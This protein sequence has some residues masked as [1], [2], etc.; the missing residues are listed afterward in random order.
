MGGLRIT[1]HMK[2]LMIL[3]GMGA[4]CILGYMAEPSLRYNLTGNHSKQTLPTASPT[5]TVTQATIDPNTLS[6]D[7]LPAKVSLKSSI[8]YTDK[9]SGLTLSFA[10]GSSVKL[11]RVEGSNVI[12]R[13]AETTLTLVVPI[14]KTD[15]MDQLAANPPSTSNV[16]ESSSP[17]NTPALGDSAGTAPTPAPTPAPIT[18]PAPAPEP[19]PTPAPTT[20]EPAPAP[21]PDATPA[22][23]PAPEPAPNT[24]PA[25]DPAPNMEPAPSPG[26][27]APTAE[28]APTPTP[29]P[30]PASGAAVDVVKAMQDSIKSGQ[31]KEFTFEQVLAWKDEG[32]ESVGGDTFQVGSCSYK[33]ET[34]FGVKTI[35]AKA[36]VKNGKVQ[37]WIGLKSGMDIK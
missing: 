11:V 4:A 18:A 12:I 25:A 9:S 27:P 13:P 14:E 26:T 21:V 34:I 2:Q 22:W 15:L 37:R 19:A 5:E 17:S 29:S 23:E 8:A 10:S 35:Q 33:A 16:K 32:T 7:Q 36:F 3:L 20:T 24:D 30:A 31:I 1:R 6:A 28:P